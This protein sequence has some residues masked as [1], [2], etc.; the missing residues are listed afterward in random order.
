MRIKI[1]SQYFIEK[2]VGVIIGNKHSFQF[3]NFLINSRLINEQNIMVACFCCTIVQENYFFSRNCNKL[4]LLSKTL[5][6]EGDLQQKLFF[7]RFLTGIRSYLEL[8]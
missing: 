1:S 7:A 5:W 2:I 3:D 4:M 6:T 8:N